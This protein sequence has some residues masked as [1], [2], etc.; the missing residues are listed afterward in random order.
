MRE[1]KQLHIT[2]SIVILRVLPP[3]LQLAAGSVHDICGESVSRNTTH[4]TPDSID[5]DSLNDCLRPQIQWWTTDF[6]VLPGGQRYVGSKYRLVLY[7]LQRRM[8]PKSGKASLSHFEHVNRMKR[9]NNS[10]KRY[11]LIQ[12]WTISQ[13]MPVSAYFYFQ[14]PHRQHHLD[15]DFMH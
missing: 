13:Y 3:Q 7:L 12:I 2:F 1:S 9:I 14:Y 4:L 6:R 11:I 15:S 8:S 10:K 5:L